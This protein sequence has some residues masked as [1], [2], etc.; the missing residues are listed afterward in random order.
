MVSLP[1][2]LR[3]L[4]T[5]VSPFVGVVRMLEEV[6]VGQDDLRRPTIYSETG[7]V[8]DLVGA[9]S[10]HSG[11][12]SGGDRRS[13]R[14]AAIGEA[15][16]RYSASFS[17]E[18][19][20]VLATARELGTQAVDPAR[21]ALFADAQL[22]TP[23]FPYAPFTD[24]TLIAWVRG[25][26]L[27]DGEPAYLPAQLVYL[28]WRRRRGEA[29]IAR[30]TSNG[31]ACRATLDEAMLTGLLEVI[32]RDAFMLTWGARLS[33]PRLTWRTASPLARFEQVHL[34]PT[35]L[36]WQAI[37]LSSIWNIPCAAGVV[38]STAAGEAPLGVGAGAAADIEAAVEK[39]LDEACRVRSWARAIRAQDPGGE[40]VVPPAEIREFDDHI[41]YYAYDEN[42]ARAAFLDGS[43]EV[44]PVSSVEP[45][46]SDP[47][48]ALRAVDE[49]LAARGA[50][51]YA[52]D[53]TAPDVRAAG[54]HVAKIIAPELCALDVEHAARFLG[55]RRRYEAPVALGLREAPLRDGE[56]NPDPHPFP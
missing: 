55:G 12:G 56:L 49:R 44:R 39:A 18:A 38:R 5:L 1:E 19:H 22:A 26:S 37:D 36:R 33:W 51:A 28:A 25:R 52:V 16:E 11:G 4:D 42:A 15:V 29:T 35:G 23:G 34:R 2:S 47:A 3:R 40:L 54:L 8:E 48:H 43:N 24:R 21:F 41:R 50:C 32:E 31:L 14:A 46:P 20:T 27:H 6:L 13:A 30:A 17:D 9:S 7:H 53:V 45:L 10:T